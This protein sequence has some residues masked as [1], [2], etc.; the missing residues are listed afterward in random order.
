VKTAIIFR[1]QLFKRSEPF[2]VQ[3]ADNLQR[4][5]PVYVGR[6]RWGDGPEGAKVVALSD[7]PGEHGAGMRL[8]L[9]A[10]RDSRSYARALRGERP[11]LIH[12]HF[13]V[14]GVYALSL[15]R[16]LRVPLVTT[17]HGFDATMS[18]SG[19]IA[20]RS[21]SWLNYV[22]FRHQLAKQ[23]Q[24]FLCVSKFIRAHVQA[25]GFPQ[26]RTRLHYIG[27]D[28]LS[29]Q[30]RESG[31]EEAVILHVAR[32][33]EKKGTRYL[34][35]AFANCM[36]RYPQ[37]RLVI[38]GE[39]PLRRSLESLAR[40]L[41]LGER[42]RF[43]GALPHEE[44]IRWVRRASVVALPSVRASNGDAEGLPIVLLEASAHGVAVLASRHAG[45]PEAAAD[46]ETGYLVE[47]RDVAALS[48]RLDELMRDGGLRRQMGARGRALVEARFDI[49]AQTASLE[50]FYDDLVRCPEKS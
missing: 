43:L 15:A 45:I 3:Q 41:S 24:L 44:V 32:L 23:G 27:I 29:V 1:Q 7:F 33:V 34:L 49:R 4:Y 22:L 26:D 38:V 2:V 10:T 5:R 17:F 14:D 42:V 6:D 48:H 28:V 19:L 35:Q 8:W 30:P 46:G 9:A 21:P 11:A 25:L 18:T 12:A 16:R 20:G 50:S 31:A 39:G 47:E 13:G 36:A 37:F 40:S